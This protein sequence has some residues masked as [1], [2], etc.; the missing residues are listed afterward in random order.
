MLSSAT[1]F[2]HCLDIVHCQHHQ[3]ASTIATVLTT[4]HHCH[5][6]SIVASASPSRLVVFLCC[7]CSSSPPLLNAFECCHW[8]QTPLLPQLLNTVS[9]VYC[10]H[11]RRFCCHWATTTA[12]ATTFVEFTVVHCQRKRQPQ[13]HHPRTNGST[14][15]KM[16]TSPDDL[17]LFNLSTIFEVCDVGRGNSAISKLLA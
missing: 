9:I 7:R 17:D 12:T 2:C 16:F 8:N 5:L 15:M 14:N 3:M 10:R 1:R 13:L 6:T 11:H 4:S